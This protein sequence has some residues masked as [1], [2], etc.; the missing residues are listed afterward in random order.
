LR[1]RKT[2]RKQE[3]NR[4]FEKSFPV[5]AQAHF[6]FFASLF[7]FTFFAFMT[8]LNNDKNSNANL[9]ARTNGEALIET[10][11]V[12][13][14]SSGETTLDA[15]AL[16]AVLCDFFEESE[17]FFPRE[18]AAL[19]AAAAAALQESGILRAC[20]RVGFRY[21]AQA[22]E[23]YELL[24]QTYLFAGFPA[25]LE[26]LAA[27]KSECVRLG[28]E[29]VPPTAAAYDLAQFRA[30]G[31]ELCRR[32]YTTA[33]DKMTLNLRAI[34]PDLADWTIIEG[35]GKT[36]SRPAQAGV[37]E[38]IRECAAVAVLATLGYDN[39]V[40]SHLRGAMNVGVTPVEC[41]EILRLADFFA[42]RAD[43]DLREI[44][45]RRVQRAHLLLERLLDAASPL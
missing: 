14:A 27:F 26:A 7:C 1:A 43:K 28:V 32:I 41:A 23:F 45:R 10:S 12:V 20:V 38:K 19:L 44:L 3:K 16:D 34:S 25:S 31:E 2:E 40:Y 4:R 36:L 5:R 39:Q 35:Y 24:L 18:Q 15:A 17:V 30:R 33:F 21:G 22:I 13:G 11:L 9:S 42:A 29:F 8:L 37:G 6:L